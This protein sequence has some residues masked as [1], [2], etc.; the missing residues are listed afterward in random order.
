MLDVKTNK[1]ARFWSFIK[2]CIEK[3]LFFSGGIYVMAS[4]INMILKKT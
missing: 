4:L 2:K 1:L 3:T